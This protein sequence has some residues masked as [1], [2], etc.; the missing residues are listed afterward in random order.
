MVALKPA[1]AAMAPRYGEI[2]V[3]ALIVTGDIDTTVSPELHAARFAA[4]VPG[5]LLEWLPGV[6]H[7]PQNVE[8]ERI[9]ALIDRLA[10][11]L[12]AQRQ[13]LPS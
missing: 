8:P 5:S 6:G 9:A 13:A 11:Q 4:A 1:V 2:A 7:M 12:A 3:P 10:E